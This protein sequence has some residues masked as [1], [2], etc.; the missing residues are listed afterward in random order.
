[1]WVLGRRLLLTG[2]GGGFLE[3]RCHG[4]GNLLGVLCP[5]LAFCVRTAGCR[6]PVGSSVVR[7]PSGLL[8]LVPGGGRRLL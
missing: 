5:G 1:M 8:A 3:D 7:V 4:V 6:V 2:A